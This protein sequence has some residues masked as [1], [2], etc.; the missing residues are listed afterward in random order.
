MGFILI[1]LDAGQYRVVASNI[2]ERDEA[3][4]DRLAGGG[5]ELAGGGFEGIV[6]KRRIKGFR[7]SGLRNGETV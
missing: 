7:I 2:L 4:P 5:F 1:F 3:A 6:G